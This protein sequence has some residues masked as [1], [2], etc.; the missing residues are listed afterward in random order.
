MKIHTFKYSYAAEI[1][2]KA[3]KAEVWEVLRDT[4]TYAQWNPFTLAVETSWKIGEPVLLTVQMKP[5]KKAILQ[6]EVLRKLEPPNE[7]SWGMKW[8]FLLNADRCQVLTEV[9]N[10]STM[11][12][13]ED[14]IEGVLSPIVHALYG[15][16][17]QRGFENV[18]KS[19]KK[20]IEDK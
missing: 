11:Y 7:M 6:K 5:D 1:E 20:Y 8:G 14:I 18:A 19:L 15:K 2:I 13:T 10:G 16:H 4:S 12:F 9:A 17:I 3:G